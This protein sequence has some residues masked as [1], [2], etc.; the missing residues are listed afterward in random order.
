MMSQVAAL[1][2]RLHL[3]MKSA[4]F[5]TSLGAATLRGWGR[6]ISTEAKS[7]T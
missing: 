4:H 1:N 2:A 6:T 3:R 5:S 7:T